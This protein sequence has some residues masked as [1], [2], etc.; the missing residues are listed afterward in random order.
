MESIVAGLFEAPP[1]F[2]AGKAE[3][4]MNLGPVLQKGLSKESPTDGCRRTLLGVRTQVRNR[5]AKSVASL[6]ALLPGQN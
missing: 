6:D 2:P 1:G 4:D 5:E 3:L